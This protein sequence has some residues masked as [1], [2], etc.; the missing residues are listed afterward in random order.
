MP[1]GTIA[2]FDADAGFGE[3]EGEDGSRWFFHCTRIED[4]SRAIDVG[5]AVSFEVVAGHLGRYE[6]TGV[7]RTR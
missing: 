5:A 3:V 4:G 2:A 1:A 7:R 6:A